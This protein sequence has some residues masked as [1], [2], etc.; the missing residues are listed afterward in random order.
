MFNLLTGFVAGLAVALLLGG[1]IVD[2]LL[3]KVEKIN[4]QLE[5]ENAELRSSEAWYRGLAFGRGWENTVVA[6][7]TNAECSCPTCVQERLDLARWEAEAGR[8]L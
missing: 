7:T 2:W 1:W 5:C 4:L 6:E 8:P 3:G